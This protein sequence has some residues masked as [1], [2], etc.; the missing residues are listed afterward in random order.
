MGVQTYV[1]CLDDE[2]DLEELMVMEAI[3]LSMQETEM[4]RDSG[5]LEVTPFRQ[6]VSEDMFLPHHGWLRL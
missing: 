4:Q 1:I 5:S 3:W 6:Y 2:V